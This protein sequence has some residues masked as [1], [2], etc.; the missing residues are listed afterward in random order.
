MMKLVSGEFFSSYV[1]LDK[2]FELGSIEPHKELTSIIPER[3]KIGV[4]TDLNLDLP[5]VKGELS[6][7]RKDFTDAVTKNVES[8][9]AK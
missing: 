1:T 3:V 7:M 4:L 9:T 2:P 8:F 6:F 5:A